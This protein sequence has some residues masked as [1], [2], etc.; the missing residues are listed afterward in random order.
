MTSLHSKVLSLIALPVILFGS[1]A[2]T[3]LAE[4]ETGNA[5]SS[6][7]ATAEASAPAEAEAE[8]P[9]EA[10]EPAGP[11]AAGTAL[12]QLETLPIKGRAPKTG[13]DRDQ[14]GPSWADVDHNGC[15][16]RND[17]LARDLTDISREGECRVMTGALDNIYGGI[18][19]VFTRGQDTSAEVQVDHVVAL[20]NAWETGAQQIDQSQREA[21]ANDPLNLQATDASSNAKKQASDAAT[22]LPPAKGYRCEYVARQISVKAA[23]ELWVTQAERSAMEGILASCPTQVAYGSVLAP[24]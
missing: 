4:T 18:D 11:A 6:I 15:D 12:E 20:M 17:I 22:W 2:C 24:L 14:F 3:P 7:S 5:S 19:V 23:Y 9:A 10:P 16:T 21:L 8:G 13:Y 1:A